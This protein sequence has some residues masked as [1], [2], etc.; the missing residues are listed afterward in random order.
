MEIGPVKAQRMEPDEVKLPAVVGH[1]TPVLAALT[2]A[3]GVSRDI[4]ASDDEIAVAWTN[5]PRVLSKVPQE[6]RTEGLARMCVAVA[7]GLF[8][9]AINYVWNCA[10]I[11]LRDKVRRFGLNVVQQVVGDPDYDDKKLLDLKDA[12]LLELCLRLNLI[13]EDGFFFLDQCRDIRN[14]FSAAHPPVGQIDDHEFLSFTNRCAKFALGSEINPVGVDI[15]AFIEALKMAGFTNDQLGAWTHRV[16]QTHEAQQELLFG[17][18]H[19]IY[20]DPS[21]SEET[22]LNAVNISFQFVSQFTPRARSEMIVRHQEYVAKGDEARHKASQLFFEKLGL[23]GLLAESERH[24]LLSSTANRLFNVHQGWDNFHNEPPF[25]QR[26]AQ[27][28]DQ[29]GV[30][31]SAKNEF[32]TVVVTC[33]VGNPYGVSNAAW[34]SYTH[35]IQRFSPAE[36]AIMLS[37]PSSNTI[38]GDRIRTKPRCRSQFKDIVRLINPATVPTKSKSIYDEWVKE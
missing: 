5:L 35:M 17:M 6:L 12:E 7:A 8:D 18:L 20:C 30:P 3:L 31:E 15:A 28:S 13:T 37:L 19:G 4:L 10:V 25:A 26:L 32:V 9:S 38:V 14:N 36:V 16:S 11:E 34:P 33:A 27:L 24:S 1:T 29:G 22:R 23:L 21:S 2:E